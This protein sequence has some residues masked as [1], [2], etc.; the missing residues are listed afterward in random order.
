MF[1]FVTKHEDK[2]NE[3]I[4]S[5]IK[6]VMARWRW[7]RQNETKIQLIIGLGNQTSNSIPF[8]KVL[9]K[10]FEPLKDKSFKTSKGNWKDRVLK[11]IKD[12]GLWW[13]TAAKNLL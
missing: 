5:L 1:F 8:Q 6:E 7:R 11:R 4:F 10:Y 12:E 2:L 9:W 3:L 13:A